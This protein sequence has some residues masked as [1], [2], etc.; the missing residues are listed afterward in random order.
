MED[1]EEEGKGEPLLLR[2]FATKNGGTEFFFCFLEEASQPRSDFINPDNTPF[3][4]IEHVLCWW[5]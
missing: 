3:H 1:G 2:L 5:E 4:P